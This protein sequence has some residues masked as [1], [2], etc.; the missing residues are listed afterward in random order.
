MFFRK[1]CNKLREEE[2]NVFSMVCG[3]MDFSF[4]Y[5]F[6]L[7]NEENGWLLDA[8]CFVNN[9]EEH[10]EFTEKQV[11][12]ADVDAL[13]EIMQKHNTI[14]FLVKYRKPR[15]SPFFIADETTYCFSVS[16]SGGECYQTQSIGTA[17]HELE[18]YFYGLAAKIN[19]ANGTGSFS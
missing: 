5:S 7:R 9:H 10:V 16:F 19:K 6:C 4:G 1:K 18:E 17:G 15:K 8:E 3:H 2:I 12:A 11:A 13:Y 14:E